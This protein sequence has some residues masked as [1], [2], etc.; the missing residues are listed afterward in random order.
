MEKPG[1]ES[2]EFD[3]EK[4]REVDQ[5]D[6]GVG[7]A[8]LGGYGDNCGQGNVAAGSELRLQVHHQ[9]V[10]VFCARIHRKKLEMMTDGT[11]PEM[12]VVGGVDWLCEI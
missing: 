1:E 11:K 7:S 3:P 2:W 9:R 5:G 4:R 12:V 8:V 6:P 10:P